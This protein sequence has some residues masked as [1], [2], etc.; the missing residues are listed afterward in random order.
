MPPKLLVPFLFLTVFTAAAQVRVWQGQHVHLRDLQFRDGN[1][2]RF[3][4]DKEISL[5]G[6]SQ[7]NW[8][9][10]TTSISFRSSGKKWRPELAEPEI[11][12]PHFA[13]CF[14]G[15][16]RTDASRADLNHASTLDESGRSR[17]GT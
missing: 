12:I 17:I 6:K 11:A 7:Q 10:S 13:Q 1:E 4:A 16:R 5:C 14:T 9:D 8:K 2:N 15:I 3:L